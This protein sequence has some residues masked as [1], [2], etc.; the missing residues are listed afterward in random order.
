MPELGH[1][2]KENRPDLPSSVTLGLAVRWT[3]QL[4]QDRDLLLAVTGPL[5]PP[6]FAAGDEGGGGEGE[7]SPPPFKVLIPLSFQADGRPPHH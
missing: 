7:K 5:V 3:G 4:G 1:F 6:S 2:H